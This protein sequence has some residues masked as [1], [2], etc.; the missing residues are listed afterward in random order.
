MLYCTLIKGGRERGEKDG[1]NWKKS[2]CEAVVDE[3]GQWRA[4]D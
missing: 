4:A 2:V 1:L 3:Y